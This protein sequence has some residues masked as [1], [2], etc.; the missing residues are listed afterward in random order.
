MKNKVKVP[1][2][3]QLSYFGKIASE[4]ANSHPTYYTPLDMGH[5]VKGYLTVTT[6]TGDVY[7][8]D[9]DQ[10]HFESFVSALLE[11]ETTCSDLE[12]N[13]E[14]YGHTYANETETSNVEDQ[15]PYGGYGY[16]EPILKGDKTLIYRGTFLY[17]VTAMA[18]SEKSEAD[19]RKNDFNP[20]YNAVSYFVTADE[21]GD[22]RDRQ[23]FT[24]A[25]AAEA[26]VL[27]KFGT[28]EAD[29]ESAG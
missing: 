13:A 4:A 25:A 6:A 24:T 15:S 19:T 3:M 27:G 18:S 10:L 29:T 22:W 9:V 7:G 21:T 2:G 5:A 14:V 26:W 8:D 12:L 11:S 28:A 23:E 17:K 1:L 20:K 16:I